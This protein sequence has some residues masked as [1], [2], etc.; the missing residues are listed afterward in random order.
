MFARVLD[1]SNSQIVD[2]KVVLE[3]GLIANETFQMKASLKAAGA[4]Y[5]MLCSYDVERYTKRYTD[6]LTTVSRYSVRELR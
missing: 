5:L 3:Y 6:I 1:F 4:A 2:C